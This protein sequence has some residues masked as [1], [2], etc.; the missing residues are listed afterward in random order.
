[1]SAT[2]VPTPA[3][4]PTR[5][6]R[7]AQTSGPGIPWTRLVAVELRKQ[8]DTRAGRWLLALVLLVDLAL[9]ALYLWAADGTRRGWSGRGPGRR[10]PKRT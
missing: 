1:M 5:L 3:A 8:V 2:T 4:R 6:A 7:S 9:M 10:A